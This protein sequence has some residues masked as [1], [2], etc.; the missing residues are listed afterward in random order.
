MRENPWHLR[1]PTTEHYQWFR[2]LV[3]LHRLTE[4]WRMETNN[5][6]LTATIGTHL[7]RKVKESLWMLDNLLDTNIEQLMDDTLPEDVL[8][9]LE[10]AIWAV[11]A[12]TLSA[13]LN[14]SEPETEL[15]FKTL[16]QVSTKL[17]RSCVEARWRPLTNRGG[18]D[19]RDLLFAL[20]DTPFSGYPNC[21][22]FLVKRAVSAEIDIELKSCPH[23]SHYSE[24]HPIASHLCTLHT[25]WMRGFTSALNSAVEVELLQQSG[26]CLQKWNLKAQEIRA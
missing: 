24:V 20:Q 11:Q 23:L 25:Y 17:G 19:L 3:D 22:G 21:N 6:N 26:R 4:A 2:N 13:I 7:G 5:E 15:L 16:E 10:H 12:K 8:A 1:I 14:K 18:Q 9:R